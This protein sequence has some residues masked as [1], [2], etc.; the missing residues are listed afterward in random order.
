VHGILECQRPISINRNCLLPDVTLIGYP[1]GWTG[2]AEH[3]RRWTARSTLLVSI[4]GLQAGGTTLPTIEP[5]SSFY[6]AH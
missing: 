6:P 3:V 1:L 4:K 5:T 2:R